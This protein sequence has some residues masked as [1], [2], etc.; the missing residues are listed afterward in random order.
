MFMYFLLGRSSWSRAEEVLKVTDLTE[1]ESMKYLVGKRKIS[2]EEAAKLYDL[3]GGRIVQ[4][5]KAANKV[6]NGIP[7]DGQLFLVAFSLAFAAHLPISL[8]VDIKHT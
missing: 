1:D 6:Q 2:P 5:K 8:I 7:F 3:F 4:L